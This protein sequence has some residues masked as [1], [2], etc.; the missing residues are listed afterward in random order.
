MD[1]VPVEIDS[2]FY[3]FNFASWKP[4]LKPMAMKMPPPMRFMRTWI[5]VRLK[6]GDLAVNEEF[7]HL[8]HVQRVKFPE[9]ASA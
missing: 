2:V 1:D 8:P 7:V 3:Q 9:A 6:P 4:S 5:L